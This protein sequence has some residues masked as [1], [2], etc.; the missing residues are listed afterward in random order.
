VLFTH[1]FSCV[2]TART[3]HGYAPQDFARLIKFVSLSSEFADILKVFLLFDKF[4]LQ[5]RYFMSTLDE[6]LLQDWNC[7]AQMMLS[8]IVQDQALSADVSTFV[9]RN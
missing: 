6:R 3:R 5:N 2:G 4:V 7:F 1:I 8:V 9:S